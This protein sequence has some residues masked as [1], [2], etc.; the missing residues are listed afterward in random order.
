[1]AVMKAA[2]EPQVR[3][4]KI[5]GF[6]YL[7]IGLGIAIV[8]LSLATVIVDLVLN[9]AVTSLGTPDARLF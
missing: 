8:V 5:S 6:K 3:Q 4:E 1:M 9:K 7:A 2:D